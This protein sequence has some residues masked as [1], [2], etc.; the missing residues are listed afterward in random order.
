[1]TQSHP[2]EVARRLAG[3]LLDCDEPP[4]GRRLLV[5]I[6]ARHLSRALERSGDSS[7]VSD[8]LAALEGP[9]APPG[10]AA[11]LVRLALRRI[12]GLRP[13]LP[14]SELVVALEHGTLRRP[15]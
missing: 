15:A 1:M 3:L 12:A 10:E 2:T 5:T 9:P 13:D 11:W 7:T 4:F 14:V 8:V 6:G